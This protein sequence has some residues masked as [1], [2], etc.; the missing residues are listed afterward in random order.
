VS[1]EDAP[2]PGPGGVATARD[3]YHC[4]ACGAEAHWNPARDALVCPYCGTTSPATLQQ[5][6]T[7]TVIVEHDLAAALV[8]AA[9]TSF[10]RQDLATASAENARALSLMEGLVAQ[11]PDV[12][13]YRASLATAE[14]DL[15]AVLLGQGETEKAIAALDRADEE[16]AHCLA[17]EPGRPE[18]VEL[19]TVLRVNR[20]Y[21]LLALG[22]HRDAVAAVTPL[23]DWP[24]WREH[25][26][27]AVVC[28]RALDQLAADSSLSED[29]S[30]ALEERYVT[31]ALELVRESV[32]LGFGDANDLRTSPQWAAL[33]DLPEFDDL[34]AAAE[35]QHKSGAAE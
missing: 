21:A 35:A 8:A 31:R 23:P 16:L 14:S 1:E 15:F 19:Q 13:E 5:R 9:S 25:M 26:S 17:S 6:G 11:H 32:H 27:A 2:P 18:L 4:P 24:R 34:V 22:R 3:K 30:A 7:E 12:A 20:G 29:E 33:R 28:L 10:E